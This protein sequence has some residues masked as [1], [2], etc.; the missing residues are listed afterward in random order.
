[1]FHFHPTNLSPPSILH[2][3]IFSL[4]YI[5]ES[6][7]HCLFY[8]IFSTS[9]QNNAELSS[10]SS[11]LQPQTVPNRSIAV[12]VLEISMAIV[13]W[14]SEAERRSWWISRRPPGQPQARPSIT[15]DSVFRSLWSV[16]SGLF[17]LV[18]ILGTWIDSWMGEAC[19]GIK[20]LALTIWY[21]KI[22]F[23]PFLFREWMT[24]FMCNTYLSLARLFLVTQLSDWNSWILRI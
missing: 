13:L 5:P 9:S 19:I 20:S 18:N 11:F 8:S 1:M 12:A 14:V 3:C 15:W 16:V 23:P 2:S 22:L 21:E 6:S 10:R 4:L 17:V 7:T 24:L